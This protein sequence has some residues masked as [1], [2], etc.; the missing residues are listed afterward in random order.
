MKAGTK[1]KGVVDRHGYTNFGM[2]RG[3]MERIVS[4]KGTD[5]VYTQKQPVVVK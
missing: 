3:S 1:I 2:A 4:L 5:T